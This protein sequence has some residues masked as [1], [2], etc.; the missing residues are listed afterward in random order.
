[1]E[2]NASHFITLLILGL[3]QAVNGSSCK[4][5]I[6]HCDRNEVSCDSKESILLNAKNPMNNEQCLAIKDESKGDYNKYNVS[7]I[8]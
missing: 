7:V 3:F 6:L 5:D 1:M 4:W 8:F 2:I